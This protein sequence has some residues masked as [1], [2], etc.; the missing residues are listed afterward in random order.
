MNNEKLFCRDFEEAVYLFIDEDM[1]AER[2]K[3]FD[4][5]LVECNKCQFLLN[6]V[7]EILTRAKKELPDDLLDAKF[8]RMIEKAVSKKKTGL[9]EFIFPQNTLKEKFAFSVKIAIVGGLAVIALVIS[10][11]SRQP[12]TIKTISNDLLDWEGKSINSQI[13][14]VKNTLDVLQENNWDSQISQ[15]DRKIKQLEKRTDKFSFN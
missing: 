12:N 9:I 5:H 4:N 8:D 13:N 1:P 3:I 15:F 11:T 10:L 6:E 14:D 2:K 7:N